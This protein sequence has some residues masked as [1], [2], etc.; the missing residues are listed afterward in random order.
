MSKF[1]LWPSKLAVVVA[2]VVGFAAPCA[3]AGVVLVTNGNDSGDGSLRAA[4]SEAAKSDAPTTI[5]VTTDSAI[6]INST[7]IYQGKVPLAIYGRGQTVS[8][9]ADTTLLTVTAGADLAVRNLNFRGRGGFSINNQGLGKGIFIAVPKDRT[10]TVQ[11]SLDRVTVSSVAYHGI[12]VSDCDLG[13]KC[14]A[15]RGGGG[16]GSPAS[17]AVRISNSEISDVGNGH[18]DADGLRVDERGPGDI[19]FDAR[20]SKFVDVGA[21]GIELDEGGTGSVFVAVID[22]RIEDNGGYCDAKVLQPFMPKVPRARFVDGKVREAD[23]PGKIKGS[24]DDACLE[25][26]VELYASGFVKTYKFSIDFDD[27]FDVDEAGP[28]D[29]WALIVGTSIR[30]NLDEGIDFGEEDEGSL[31]I[32]VWHS[33]AKGNGDEGFKVVESGPGGV[34]GHFRD[35]IARDNG[36][37]G[38][39]LVQRDQGD[40]DVLVDRVTTSNN[41]KGKKSGFEVVQKGDGKGTLTIRNSKISDGVDAVNVKVIEE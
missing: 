24:P 39:E 3:A 26:E 12:H 11:V 35:V 5:L 9:V 28:G 10:G 14:G 34:T 37:K 30:R 29:L 25:R 33:V 18:F 6:I 38:A 17:V 21:D 2:A 4:L 1:C 32:A 41:D 8:T 15:G 31:N 13:D 20:D 40:I 22:S 19:R 27:A 7:L 36:G 16:D 23:I